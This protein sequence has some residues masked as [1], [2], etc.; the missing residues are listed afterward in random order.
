MRNW[1]CSKDIQIDFLE[2]FRKVENGCDLDNILF[3]KQK[4]TFWLGWKGL[5]FFASSDVL[6]PCG[7]EH[8]FKDFRAVRTLVC[9]ISKLS[10]LNLNSWDGWSTV[11]FQ[12]AKQT[13]YVYGQLSFSFFVHPRHLIVL[14]IHTWNAKCSGT[15]HS[16]WAYGIPVSSGCSFVSL[17]VSEDAVLS[18]NMK[19]VV[20]WKRKYMMQRDT[21]SYQK[22]NFSNKILTVYCSEPFHQT[23]SAEF[24]LLHVWGGLDTDHGN[25]YT[26]SC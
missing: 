10:L 19:F 25:W 12:V 17:S 16:L 4:M 26:V 14:K 21:A 11:C 6:S 18:L 1:L 8:G 9:V 23:K 15:S 7:I 5:R 24:E 2:L 13:L 3:L 22:R 20:V